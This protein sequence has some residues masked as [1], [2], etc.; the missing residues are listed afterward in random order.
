MKAETEIPP[1]TASFSEYKGAIDENR[2]AL[3]NILVLKCLKS[4]LVAMIIIVIWV[5]L[6]VRVLDAEY[7]RPFGIP[8]LTGSQ[9]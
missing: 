2:G 5:R 4:Q 6:R 7:L 9:I 8:S 1:R 3:G